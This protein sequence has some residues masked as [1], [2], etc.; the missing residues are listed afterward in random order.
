MRIQNQAHWHKV[1]EQGDTQLPHLSPEREGGNALDFY[2]ATVS[3][4]ILGRFFLVLVVPLLLT[5]DFL[6]TSLSN[7]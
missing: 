2:R 3:P 6:R 7:L 1:K 4:V 5:L